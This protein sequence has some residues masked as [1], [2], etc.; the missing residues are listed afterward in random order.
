MS[1]AEPAAGT[2]HSSDTPQSGA[3]LLPAGL[4]LLYRMSADWSELLSLNGQQFPRQG[5]QAPP[6]WMHRYLPADEQTRVRGHIEEAVRELKPFDLEHR[7]IRR[8]GSI[9]WVHSRAMPLL[10]PSGQLQSWIGM[11]MDVTE[12]RREDAV[13]LA[14]LDRQ[15]DALVREVHHRIKNH[16]QGLVGLLRLQADRHPGMAAP[17]REVMA[18]IHAIAAVYGLGGEPGSAGVELARV[19]ESVARGAGAASE[20][21][22]D[23]PVD[24]GLLLH[25]DHAVPIA[26]AINEL[27]ANACKHVL[28][29]HAA[30]TGL[31][32]VSL[33]QRA[34]VVRVQVDNAPARLPQGFDFSQGLGLGTGLQLLS[35]LLPSQGARLRLSQHGEQVRARLLLHAPVLSRG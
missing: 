27:V 7:T 5:G 18:Q 16:L 28:P 33:R 35:T 9:G 10:D 15:R 4:D 20:V 34:G 32:R 22:L 8:D 13:R 19:I 17:M 29:G 1:K 31:L 23:V 2:S 12:R 25:P 21:E 30:Q 14:G 11:A 26:L 3:G 24:S 6:D